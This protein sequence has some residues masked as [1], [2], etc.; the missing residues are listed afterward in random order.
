[1]VQTISLYIYVASYNHLG[2]HFCSAN[3]KEN[4]SFSSYFKTNKQTSKNVSLLLLMLL[5][6][7]TFYL[8]VSASIVWK[9]EWLLH[10]YVKIF[11]LLSFVLVE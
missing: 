8:I 6:L 2:I 9:Q 10:Q 7:F 4:K 5:L 3:Q 11:I 1:M